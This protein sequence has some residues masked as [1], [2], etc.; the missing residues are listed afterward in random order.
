MQESTKGGEVSQVTR[1]PDSGRVVRRGV[2]GVRQSAVPIAAVV[3]GFVIWQIVAQ[4][5]VRNSLF[6]ASP[7]Q[8][9][10]EIPRMWQD[11]S[12]KIDLVVSGQEALY[13]FVVGSAAGILIGTVSAKS[14]L[15][16]RILAPYIYGLYATPLLALAPIIILWLGLG[17]T[18][19]V[20]VAAMLVVF[21]VII[22]TEAGI[23][24]VNAEFR[25]LAR[26]FGAG[27]FEMFRKIDMPAA[28]PYVLAGL[29]LAIGR[30]LTGVIVGE[31]FGA[32]HGLGLAIFTAQA[33]F[34]TK[35][36]FGATS[37]FAAAGIAFTYLL[38][39]VERILTPWARD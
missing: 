4:Y 30:A 1:S 19:K 21:P 9:V 33:Q 23:Q 20:F 37:I 34:D 39:L 8:T 2:K 15:G 18:S 12:L 25:E 24:N 17:M 32:T 6:L 36:L 35:T 5:V 38:V 22:N 11:G 26:S 28:L 3:A 16:S 31:L 13:G 27:R 7:W 29:R 14:K 10:V